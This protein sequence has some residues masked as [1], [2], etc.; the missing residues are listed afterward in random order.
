M[1]HKIQYLIKSQ[2]LRYGFDFCFKERFRVREQNHGVTFRDTF[3]VEVVFSA[4]K[5]SRSRYLHNIKVQD[6]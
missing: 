1:V 5:K 2:K 4:I 3:Q 6:E